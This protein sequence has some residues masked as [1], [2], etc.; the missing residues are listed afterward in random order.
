[1][2]LLRNHRLLFIKGAKVAGTS[3]EVFLSGLAGA[4]DIV[5]PISPPSPLHQP[6]NHLAA[7][8]SPR[9]YNHIDAPTVK[10]LLGDEYFLGLRRFGVVRDPFEKVKSTFAMQYVLN[11]GAYDVDAAIAD[12][13]S[14]ADKYCDA[15]G[16]SLLTDVLRYEDLDRELRRFFESMGIPFESLAAREKDDFKKRSGVEAQFDERQ[17]AAILEKFSWEFRNFYPD[18]LRGAAK[19]A[20]EVK[21]DHA[22]DLVEWHP[23]PANMSLQNLDSWYL[24]GGRVHVVPRK[25]EFAERG[26]QSLVE[27]WLPA[28]PLIGESTRVIGVGS[29]FARYFILWLAENGFNKSVD[30]SPYNALMRYG[31]TFESP[32]VIAQQFRWAF[33]EFDSHDALW[34]G[35]DKEVFEAN[36]ERRKMVRAT[37][38]ATDVLILTL[39]LSEVWYDKVTGEPLWRALTKR[40]YDPARHVFR[41]ETMADTKRSLEKIEEIRK[42]HLPNLKI[43]YTV[44]P[45]RMTATF[46]PVSA[47]TANSVSKAILR[48]SL[49]EFLRERSELVNRELFYFPSYEIVHD[50]F[51]D[52]F[53]EDNRHVATFVASRIVQSFARYYCE[54]AMLDRMGRG[55]A[56]TGSQKLD[57]FLDFAADAGRDASPDERTAR[58]ADLERQIEDLQRTCDARSTVI[59]ELDKAARERLALVEELHHACAQLREE[60]QAR[61]RAT[62]T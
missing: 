2:I 51:R 9:F 20:S 8:G 31:A 21:M 16:E 24:G 22:K 44:S 17:R 42:R 46:R 48:A 59:A 27:G 36:D 7:N 54:P 55:E 52:P 1:M 53:E 30:T 49:D 43:V 41:V 56:A 58:I 61:E 10:S 18:E 28:A 13:W 50:F 4:D 57:N 60:L 12:T 38:E 3:I 11:N 19:P 23:D 39:G 32:A 6:R 26:I 29:C 25:K 33:G 40:H 47:I 45:V 62:G 34:I 5:T 14:E 35:K 37:L 15:R